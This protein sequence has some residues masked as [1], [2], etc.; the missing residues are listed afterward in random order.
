VS[1]DATTSDAPSGDGPSDGTGDDGGG[2][3]A[4]Q[5]GGGGP[6]GCAAIQPKPLF[7]EDFDE[8]DASPGDTS[9]T[10]GGT[11]TLDTATFTSSPRSVHFVVPSTTGG[12]A[13]ARI[14]LDFVLQALP[15]QMTF[16][17]DVRVDS[18]DTSATNLVTLELPSLY[19]V[20]YFVGDPMHLREGVPDDAGNV[21]F[22]STDVSAMPLGKWVH[23]DMVFAV[24]S[25]SS[26]VTLKYDAQPVFTLP[27]ALHEFF[28]THV[29][30][31]IGN[32]FVNAG[33]GRDVHADNIVFDAR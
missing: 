27:L 17:F 30:V 2:S 14:N 9:M 33:A 7:C 20:G 25:S 16:S 18:A 10:A 6:T 5:E 32:T 3:D 26:S 4:G 29:G 28:D 15:S 13:R 21:S 12:V 31:Q 24:G 11:V 22:V 23:V 19:E 1:G 8:N